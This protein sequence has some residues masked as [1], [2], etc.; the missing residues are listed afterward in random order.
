MKKFK[1]SKRQSQDGLDQIIQGSVQI[2]TMC[3]TGS[4]STLFS[5]PGGTFIWHSVSSNKKSWYCETNININTLPSRG[6][7][8]CAEGWAAGRLREGGREAC[9]HIFAAF[10]PGS[11]IMNEQSC[12]CYIQQ[13]VGHI[14]S[15]YAVKSHKSPPTTLLLF[16]FWHL[17]PFCLRCVK[18]KK[19]PQLLLKKTPP[20]NVV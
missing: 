14:S 13:K 11:Y 1:M 20:K 8:S 19:S 2:S 7:G 12:S 10:T 17:V 4:L 15:L 3:T 16:H 18:K 9:P 6:V 5:S